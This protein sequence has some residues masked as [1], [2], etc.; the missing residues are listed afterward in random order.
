MQTLRS[1]TEKIHLNCAVTKPER[2][3]LLVQRG[4]LCYDGLK[5]TEWDNVS[6]KYLVQNREQRG[7]APTAVLEHLCSEQKRCKAGCGKLHFFELK[8]LFDTH[9]R[10]QF[11]INR[12]ILMVLCYYIR[13]I[14]SSVLVAKLVK[15]FVVFYGTQMFVIQ[16]QLF[17]RLASCP[18][19]INF[20]I[21]FS[22][23]GRY[24]E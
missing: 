22:Y 13:N 7:F 24:S 8:S 15:D 2:R 4:G 21:I 20:V 16:F 5:E 1:I 9:G 10:W 23:T 14:F 18:L 11:R 17:C 3:E 19:K 6:W 12:K